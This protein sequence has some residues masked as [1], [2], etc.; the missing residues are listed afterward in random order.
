MTESIV[1]EGRHIRLE[2]LDHR[3]IDGLVAASVAD[4]SLYRWSAVPQG[5]DEVARYVE[6]ALAW[7]DAGTALPFATIRRADGAVI[8]STR[9]WNLERW[10]WPPQHPSHGRATPDACE[11]GHTWLTRAAVRTAA[12]TEAKL[13]MLAHAFEAWRVLRVCLHTDARNE[14]S[15]AAIERIGGT[16]EGVLRAH[17]MAADFIPR[18]SF[19]FSILAEEWPAVKARLVARLAAGA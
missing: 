2:P 13:L 10:A 8:G 12:N 4:P 7:R 14:R 17:R 1:L 16:F 6:T 5:K 3:H 18:D 19:R 11:I 15:R 9:F